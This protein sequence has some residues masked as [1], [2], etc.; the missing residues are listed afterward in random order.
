[1]G[2]CWLLM[3]RYQ[4]C[5]VLFVI[6]VVQCWFW[7]FIVLWV[8][9]LL[10]MFMMVKVIFVLL[11]SL[12]ICSIVLCVQLQL[13]FLVLVFQVMMLFGVVYSGMLRKLCVL[14]YQCL[15]C[16]FLL[17]SRCVYVF[18]FVDL[19]R[20]IFILLL[21]LKM[22]VMSRFLL[23][24]YCWFSVVQVGLLGCFI[25]MECISGMLVLVVFLVL[26]YRYGMSWCLS[27][28]NMCSMLQFF[29]LISQGM[30][31]KLLLCSWLCEDIRLN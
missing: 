29:L 16:F 11:F 19:G 26:V 24:W 6:L 22:G 17:D 25:S 2:L 13:G 5:S 10:F 8:V 21:L 28:V 12:N 18:E 7:W 4:L 23:S 14:W 31:Q 20:Q 27:C 9:I 15:F 1:M 3:F 30:W